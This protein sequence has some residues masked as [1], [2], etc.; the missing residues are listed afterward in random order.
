MPS[1]SITVSAD[2]Q[3]IEGKDITGNVTINGR[4]RCTVC[5]CIIRHPGGI[6]VYVKNTTDFAIHDCEFFNTQAPRGVNP[7][8]GEHHAIMFYAVGGAIN[9]SRVTI[10]DATGLYADR[11]TGKFTISNFEG[12]NM[13]SPVSPLRGQLVQLNHCSGGAVI[14]D[15][16]AECDP[17]NSRPEDIINIF[18]CTGQINIRRGLIDGGN[19]RSAVL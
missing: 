15:F 4:A 1:G 8:N 2:D 19:S 9:V 18:I 3:V 6:G 7:T 12:H 11:V 16:S 5:N 10:H 17:A 13:R 14:E